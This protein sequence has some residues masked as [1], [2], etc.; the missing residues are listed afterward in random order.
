MSKL[1]VVSF[2]FIIYSTS[3]IYSSYHVTLKDNAFD[4]GAGKRVLTMFLTNTSN[5]MKAI[6]M[7][8]KKRDLKMDGTE[9]VSETEDLVVIPSQLIL[10]PNA[11]QAVSLR[12]VGDR[13]IFKE[14]SYRVI[15]EELNVGAKQ[16]KNTKMIR[17]KIKFIKAIYVAPKVIKE[18]IKV[19]KVY[20]K[21]VKGKS[22]LILVVANNGTVHIVFHNVMLEYS[23][24]DNKIGMFQI[25]ATEL[26]PFKKSV[27]ILPGIAIEGWIPWP[28]DV[29]E[30]TESFGLVAYN[31]EDEEKKKKKK[32][33]KKKKKK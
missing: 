28:D 4:P 21:I 27:N 7:T 19:V 8:P 29:S 2:F 9:I 14:R 18:S 32:D 23:T 24:E 31:I 10:P 16:Q 20:R 26:E 11:E 25:N 13:T 15:V 5:S 12:W 33:E 1:L 17:T 3:V 6:E 22:R 30:A